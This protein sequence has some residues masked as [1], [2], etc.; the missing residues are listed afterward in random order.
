MRIMVL[1]PESSVGA[2]M[3]EN[4]ELVFAVDHRAHVV[5]RTPEELGIPRTIPDRP[6][7]RDLTRTPD[8]GHHT[9]DPGLKMD[10]PR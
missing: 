4:G 5:H 1:R 3:N 9:T 2:A 8:R 6:A 10:R 7:A